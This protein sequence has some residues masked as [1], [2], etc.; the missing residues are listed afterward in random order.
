MSSRERYWSS[1][2]RRPTSSRSPRRLWWSCLCTLR[3]SVRPLIRFVSSATWTSGEPVSPSLVAW[4]AMISFFISVSS[5]K[6]G[7]LFCRGYRFARSGRHNV[8]A[9]ARR[10]R[11]RTRLASRSASR[12]RAQRN[13]AVW[14]GLSYGTT[15]VTQPIP[16]P[17]APA[18]LAGSPE[19]LPGRGDVVSHL[20]D[21]FIDR[22]ELRLAAQARGE[23]NGDVDAVKVKVIAIERVGLDGTVD[24]VE[25]RI[26]A[27]RYRRWP[28]VGFDPIGSQARQPAGVDRIGRNRRV[29]GRLGVRGGKAERPA[30]LAAA[31]YDAFDPMRSA[32][33]GGSGLDLAGRQQAPD[34]AGRDRD[35]P[36]G[37]KRHAFSDELVL[38]AKLA[39]QGDVSRRFVPEPE[40]LPD[41]DRRRV[42]AVDKYGP[43]EVLGRQLRELVGEWHNADGVST[44][45]AEQL[46]TEPGG[47]QQRGMRAW[48]D[49]LIGMRIEGD[50]DQRQP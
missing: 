26:R 18:L 12:M 35:A 8:F 37:E 47:A 13:L 1:R 46:S 25:R 10:G 29:R 15:P 5:G 49:H 40:V 32:K 19:H 36:I 39:E 11:R 14:F 43:D 17:R 21:E 4:A 7:S 41:H 33:L 38:L 9:R 48:P 28:A 24:A 42:Q 6:V 45:P 2:L 16:S 27:D 44:E 31:D 22:G 23:L 34:P 3:C 30:A 20:C 50:D